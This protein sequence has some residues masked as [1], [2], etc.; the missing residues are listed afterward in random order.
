[1]FCKGPVVKWH[2]TAFALPGREFDSPR[3][4]K[5]KNSF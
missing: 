5:I 4:H 2:Y 3:V 1:M